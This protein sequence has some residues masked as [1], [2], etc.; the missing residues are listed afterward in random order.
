MLLLFWGPDDLND[1]WR[2][3]L[4]FVQTQTYQIKQ[5]MA[6]YKLFHLHLSLSFHT[7]SGHS[8]ARTAVQAET[9]W[10]C[11]DGREH[12]CVRTCRM[13]LKSSAQKLASSLI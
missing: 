12:P 11:T 13:C 6:G 9:V 10:C 7:F 2:E 3:S 8:H 5:I 1:G 4:R